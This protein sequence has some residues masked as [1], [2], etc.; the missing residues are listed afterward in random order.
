M[1]SDAA[2]AAMD[3]AHQPHTDGDH[4]VCRTCRP[5]NGILWPCL[6]ARLLHDRAALLAEVGRATTTLRE[7]EW[8]GHGGR[9]CPSCGAGKY[10]NLPHAPTCPIGRYFAGRPKTAEATE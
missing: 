5:M 10:G 9:V 8:C 4:V 7:V 6:P 1:L 3:A 2:V